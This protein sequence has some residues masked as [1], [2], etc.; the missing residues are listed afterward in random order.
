MSR[1]FRSLV[2]TVGLA[3][4]IL[5]SAAA[6]GQYL[7]LS[8]QLHQR[9]RDNL[10]ASAQGMLG[11][12]AF[13][14]SWRL[15]G[16]RRT[17]EGPDVYSVVTET[18]TLVDTHGYLPG[19]LGHVSLPF[20]FD[21]DRPFKFSSDVGENWNLYVHKLRDGI[22]ILGV[23]AE[24]TPEDLQERFIANASRFGSNVAD[25][26][27]T[28][29]RA[30]HESFDWAI[31]DLNGTLRWAIGGIPM[32]IAVPEIP[33]TPALSPVCQVGSGYYSVFFQPVRSRSG[34]KVGV[35]TVL[36]DI[37][38]ERRVLH[39]SAIFNLLVGVS[40]WF[41]TVAFAILYLRRTR[42]P[43][44]TCAQ[45][46]VLQESDTVEFKSSL[47]WN[48]RENRPDREMEKVVV[49]TVAGF[50]NSYTGGNLI[51]GLD[52]KGQVLGLQADYSTLKTRSNRDGFEQALRNVLV[53]A[54][55]EGSCA[56]WMKA[57]FCSLQDKE[58]CMIKISPAT[59]PMYPKEKG[60]EDSALY[61]RLGNTTTPLSGRE[62]VA[63][64]RERWGGVSLRRSY[65]RRPTMQPAA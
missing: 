44:I 59:E 49:K 25:A 47:R 39:Q 2:W 31:V 40:L 56:A 57:S 7:F 4:A 15:Q 60:I 5:F 28:P 9:I 16:Y 65:F 29:E 36:E 58:L 20:L 27:H 24:I 42:V 21:F 17:T 41:I 48:D 8:Y 61:V 45:I 37:S 22:V 54:F 32:K 11:D 52:D 23:R 62:A 3:S 51:I 10:Q 55:G 33:D 18:G 46:P 14:D 35:I 43:E 26:T 50:L 53:N 30:I 38:A 64:F 6:S 19:M 13:E 12:I 1:S 34:R 63:Y